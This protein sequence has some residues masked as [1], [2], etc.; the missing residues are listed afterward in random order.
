MS[1]CLKIYWLELT[2][3]NFKGLCL[4]SVK[5]TVKTL[6]EQRFN[7]AADDL[8]I[9]KDRFITTELS[10]TATVSQQQDKKD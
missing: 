3:N 10:S 1:L 9:L 5:D 8:I 2:N 4:Y 7:R 6:Q